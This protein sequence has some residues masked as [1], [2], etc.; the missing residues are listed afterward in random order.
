MDLDQLARRTSEQVAARPSR[1]GI[2]GAATKLAVGAGALLAGLRR[3]EVA[4]IQIGDSC[5]NGSGECPKRNGRRR[6][7]RHSKV[8]YTWF[9]TNPSGVRYLCK[10]CENESGQEVC[11][12]AKKQ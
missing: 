2:M 12:I 3:G 9:C 4:A 5:C 8:G 11:V 7:P 10:D 6:C 1:R